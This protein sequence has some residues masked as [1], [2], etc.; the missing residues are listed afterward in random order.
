MHEKMVAV[1]AVTVIATATVALQ[2]NQTVTAKNQKK[3]NPRNQTGAL[4]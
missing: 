3:I 4:N 2:P 1:V